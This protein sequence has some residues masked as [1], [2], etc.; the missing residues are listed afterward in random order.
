[1]RRFRFFI[2]RTKRSPE[3]RHAHG[4]GLRIGYWPCVKGPYLQVAFAI[5]RADLWHGLAGKRSD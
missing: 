5:W 1:M 3:G 2:E 4:Y